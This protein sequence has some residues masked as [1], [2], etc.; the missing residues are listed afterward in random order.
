MILAK[1]SPRAGAIAS[2]NAVLF[3]ARHFA[4]ASR[5]GVCIMRAEDQI[6]VRAPPRPGRPPFFGGGDLIS[7]VTDSKGWSAVLQ[8]KRRWPGETRLAFLLR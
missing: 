3:S 2:G 5:L 7:F 1:Y 8:L 6:L 4:L